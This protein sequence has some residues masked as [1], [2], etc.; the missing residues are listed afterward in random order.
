[1]VD[2]DRRD[3]GDLPVGDVRRVPR[4]THADL[5]DGDID[6]CVG[7]GSEAI[8]VTISKNDSGCSDESSTI[9]A[10]A[11]TSA[12]ASTN[13]LLGQRHAVEA[14]ALGHRLQVRAG[15]APRAQIEGAQQRVDHAARRGLAVGAGEMD[16]RVGALR[17]AQQSA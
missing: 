7:E 6:G 3:D 8:A 10:Y 16:D 4:A 17:I 2:A 12:K 5:D 15:E 13:K 14:D 11:A 1:M 9:W